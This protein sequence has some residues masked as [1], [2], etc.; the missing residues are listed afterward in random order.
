[1]T[2]YLIRHSEAA[3]AWDKAPNPVLS[4]NGVNQAK[5]LAEKYFPILKEGDFQLISSPLARAQ[6]TAIP[7]Q[8][9]LNIAVGIS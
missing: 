3:Q 5:D 9:G 6:Q 8:K 2:I 1:M 7:F 4:Q